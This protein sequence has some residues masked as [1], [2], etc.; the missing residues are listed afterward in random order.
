MARNGSPDEKPRFA[1]TLSAAG[2]PYLDWGGHGPALHFA[3]ANGFPP[4]TYSQFVASLTDQFHVLGME[5]RALWG[6]QDP[7]RFGGWRELA[8]DLTRFLTEVAPQG[9]VAVGHS[10]G[11]VTS[12]YCAIAHPQLVRALVLID[13][14][15]LPPWA[16][17]VWALAS[18][19]R[20]KGRFRIVA[21]A[22]RRRVEWPSRKVLFRAYR[23]ASVFSLW[24]DAFVWDYVEAGTAATTDGGVRLRYPREWEARVF[25]TTPA[26]VW[27]D[28]PRLPRLPLLVLRGQYSRT[29]TRE[30]M[31]IMSWLL[32][33]G[34][35][36]EIAGADHFVPMA[37][38]EETL[39]A[40]RSFL[41]ERNLAPGMT[42]R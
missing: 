11:A 24:Q 7:G 36:L 18:L 20:L 26:C 6:T 22:R 10:L 8:V 40:I 42:A 12:L 29:F 33:H 14:V 32:P 9:V 41:K 28:L 38:R 23:A 3:H 13:P 15:I 27:L 2:I 31:R 16:A 25:E 19:L 30:T 17:P 34:M 35:F 4:G 37:R 5:C 39:A 21:H 1:R